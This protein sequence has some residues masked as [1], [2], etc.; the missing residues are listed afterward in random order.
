MKAKFEKQKAA[1]MAATGSGTL[2]VVGTHFG[3]PD[4]HIR[5]K[6]EPL[7]GGSGAGTQTRARG[8]VEPGPLQTIPEDRLRKSGPAVPTT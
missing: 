7:T 1:S 3:L 2:T 4:S 5:V 8:I 6:S